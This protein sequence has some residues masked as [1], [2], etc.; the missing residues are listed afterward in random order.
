MDALSPPP[1]RIP[2]IDA[3]GNM[4]PV[5]QRWFL[6]LYARVGVQEASSNTDIDITD[7]FGDWGGNQVS[8]AA[9][10]EIRVALALQ[11]EHQELPPPSFARAMLLMGG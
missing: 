9:L 4:P 2:I 10:E 1:T 5:W 8:L 6:R 7:A 11:R 3:D